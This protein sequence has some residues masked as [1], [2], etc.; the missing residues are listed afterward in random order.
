MLTNTKQKYGSISKFFHWAIALFVIILVGVGLYMAELPS[1]DPNKGTLFFYHK[2][3]G[4]LVLGLV[5][6][7]LT[8]RLS[9]RVPVMPIGTPQ[10]KH[11]AAKSVHFL[12]YVLMFV[13]P[14]SGIL[15]STFGNHPIPF[16]DLYT[17]P[18]QERIPSV[19]KAALNVHIFVGMAWIAL[20]SIHILAALHHHFI[21]KDNVFK[22]M[23]PW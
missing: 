10:W 16:F 9:N 7:R 13:G 22:R 19:A 8:W 23:L 12:L 20:I 18:G 15:M 3:F 14:I 11:V 4:V 17:F 5:T 1:T 21:E 6:L 2:S